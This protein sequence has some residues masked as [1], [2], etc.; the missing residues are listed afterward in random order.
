[1]SNTLC[2]YPWGSAAIRPNGLTIPCCRFPHIDDKDSFVSSPTVRNT[3]TWNKIREDMLAG[4]PVEGCKSCY[5]DESNGLT[6]MRQHSLKKFVPTENK[7]LPIEQLEVS[8]S[9]LCNLACVHCSNFF[10]TKWYSEDVKAGRLEKSGVLNNDFNFDKWDLS[11]IREIKIIGGEP[12]MEQ[13]K[14]IKFLSNINLSNITLQICTNGTIL[15]N[16]QLKL[17]IE[18]CKKVYL[19]VSMDGLGTT[20]DWYRWPGKFETVIDNIK[21]YE[22]WWADNK[23]IVPII[24]HVINVI[25]ILELKDF[26]DYMKTNF[27]R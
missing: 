7:V 20:N 15:P 23:Q 10:S 19:C 16:Q 6:S 21:R 22:E 1:M 13:D 9:N 11:N 4:N 12:F 3:P 14:F 25:N 27:S 18:K 17:L 24:H 2:A 8:F 5:Q 26:V